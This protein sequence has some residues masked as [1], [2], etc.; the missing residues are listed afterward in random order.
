MMTYVD[1][2][3]LKTAL[4]VSVYFSGKKEESLEHLNELEQLCQTYGLEVVAKCPCVIRAY[5]AG[6]FLGEGKLE[7]LKQEVAKSGAHVVI[8]DDEISPHQQRNL[9]KFFHCPVIDRT[10]LIIEVFA[11]R[12][13]TKEAQLQIELAKVKY[14]FPRLKRMWTHLSRQAG[15]ASSGGGAYLKG[16]GEKQIEIDRRLLKTRIDRLKGEIEQVALHRKTQRQQRMR[17][18]VPTI[19]IVGYTNAGKSTL[20]NALSQADVLAENKLFATLD[21][22]TRKFILPNRHEVLLIDTVGFI[23]KIPHTLV[24]AFKSTLEESVHTDL[25]LHVVDVS[26]PAAENQAEETMQVLKELGANQP[27][28]TVLNKIDQVPYPFVVSKF[29]VKYPKVVAVSA[30]AGT[31]FDELQQ[32]IIEQLSSLRKVVHCKIPQEQY[33]LIAELMKE[34]RVI[35]SDYEENDVIL[36]VEIPGRLEHKLQPFLIS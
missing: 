16:E 25:L 7:E 8:F 32:K 15:T 2:K 6:T 23:R 11:Q 19:G 26:H 34:G 9:E 14:Q 24:A 1:L 35:E 5:D 17:T 12:A 13:Q 21:T 10:E 27:V 36:R 20:F 33:G 4:L 31:G 30:L 18:G 29:R 3:S 28:I 22:T